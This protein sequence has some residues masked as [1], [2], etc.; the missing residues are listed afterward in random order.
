MLRVKYLPKPGHE[1]TRDDLWDISRALDRGDDREV[2]FSA[3]PMD[4]EMGIEVETH[5]DRAALEALP[6]EFQ[7]LVKGEIVADQRPCGHHDCSVSSGIHEGLTFGRGELDSMG[8]WEFP[9]AVCARHNEENHPEDGVC[10]PFSDQFDEEEAER[11]LAVKLEALQAKANGGAGIESVRE[12]CRHLAAN[13]RRQARETC[14]RNADELR[15]LDEIGRI[16]LRAELLAH[17]T[18]STTTAAS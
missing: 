17:P 8:F 3:M 15:G 7:G 9:C 4:D 16:L 13:Q 10:W 1:V 5:H 14:E 6:A 12:V 18:T 2:P 11:R